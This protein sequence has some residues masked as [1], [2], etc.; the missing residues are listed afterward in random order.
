[1]MVK[2]INY[3]IY[4]QILDVVSW[5]L[6]YGAPGIYIQTP[7][8][9]H[10]NIWPDI[11]EKKKTRYCNDI[12]HYV[13]KISF[14]LSIL[15]KYTY[16]NLFSPFFLI[17]IIIYV[18]IFHIIWLSWMIFHFSITGPWEVF[19]E[20]FPLL[21][22]IVSQ[23]LFSCFPTIICTCFPNIM[24]HVFPLLSVHVYPILYFMISQY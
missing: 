11:N 23:I 14:G 13:I 3:K 10:N 18:Y 17:Y 8:K 15:H 24:F 12:Y 16:F 4:K 1:M 9:L 21:Y 20:V 6:W 2:I 22:V 7:R 19:I 5:G